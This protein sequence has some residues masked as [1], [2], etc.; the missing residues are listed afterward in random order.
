MDPDKINFRKVTA[1]TSIITVFVSLA[2]VYIVEIVA[3]ATNDMDKADDA[4]TTRTQDQLGNEYIYLEPVTSI[5]PGETHGS[6]VAT[7][8]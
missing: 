7:T 4:T 1:V 8:T 3:R 5:S 2:S 6:A